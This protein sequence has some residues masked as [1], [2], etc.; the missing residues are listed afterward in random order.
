MQVES[1]FKTG[2]TS[3]TRDYGLGQINYKTAKHFGIDTKRL[4]TDYEY[5]IEQTIRILSKLKGQFDSPH[6]NWRAWYTRYHS[7]TPEFRKVYSNRLDLKFAAI[8]RITN[9]QKIS[10]KI[11]QANPKKDSRVICRRQ[12]AYRDNEYSSGF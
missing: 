5:A 3:H 7:Y 6:T 11:D 8:K 12:I 9:E 2:S 1:T 4:L 10:Q